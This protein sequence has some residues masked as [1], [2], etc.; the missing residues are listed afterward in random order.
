MATRAG[1]RIGN[2][3]TPGLTGI[4]FFVSNVLLKNKGYRIAGQIPFDMPSNW[5]FLH[6]T[7]SQKS[8][9]F[10]FEKNRSRVRKQME[11]LFSTGKNFLSHRD[12]LQD[13]LI[14]PISL[15]YSLAGK[16]VFAKSYYASAECTN[17]NKC[18]NNCPAKAIKRANGRPFWTF[19]C[20]SCM[21]CMASCPEKAIESAHGLMVVV[22][23]LSS[24]C[25]SW[26]SGLILADYFH[27]AVVRI[28]LFTILLILFLLVFYKIQHILLR[29]KYLARLIVFTSLTHY[30]FWGKR[31][32]Q[33]RA[34]KK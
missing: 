29:N 15:G 19:R 6:P 17:C 12:F 31:N 14:S 30:K 28:L 22:S 7:L 21:K 23:I 33:K 4:A 20:Q 2:V 32:P 27:S 24:A 26:M 1:M 18:I 11:K 9:D 16:Y 13:A 5:F 10:I 3:V 8:V 25:L 34:G